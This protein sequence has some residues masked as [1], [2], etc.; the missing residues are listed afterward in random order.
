M[1]IVRRVRNAN[2]D[3]EIIAHLSTLV[4]SLPIMVYGGESV[5]DE[6]DG[7]LV[8]YGLDQNGLDMLEEVLQTFAVT[9]TLTPTPSH[10]PT[11]TT[12]R[13]TAPTPS[14]STVTSTVSK[15]TTT[16]VTTAQTVTTT[17]TAPPSVV[18][19]PEFTMPVMGLVIAI[20]GKM[21]RAE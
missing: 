13:P 3:A 10:S 20:I 7:F 5:R 16:T 18:V 11:I 6:V 19:R 9:P 15:T 21:R 12:P 1:K 17:V 4:S 14:P 8:V 2:P